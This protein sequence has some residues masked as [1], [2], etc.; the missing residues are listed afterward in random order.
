MNVIEEVGMLI[1][2]S[3]LLVDVVIEEVGMLIDCSWLLI[4]ECY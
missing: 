3:W 2:C 1:D 4:D